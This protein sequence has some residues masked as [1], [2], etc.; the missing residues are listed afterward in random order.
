MSALPA[1]VE[2]HI[3]ELVKI[4]QMP[5]DTSKSSYLQSRAMIHS[6]I[7]RQYRRLKLPWAI[8]HYEQARECWEKIR[9]MVRYDVAMRSQML[10]RINKEVYYPLAFA[11][12]DESAR[13]HNDAVPGY[14]SADSPYQAHFEKTILPSLSGENGIGSCFSIL[15]SARARTF[16]DLAGR[17]A[18]MESLSPVT[19]ADLWPILCGEKMVEA[20]A[21]AYWL[22][23]EETTHLFILLPKTRKIV[24]NLIPI[25]ADQIADTY[26]QMETDHRQ[27]VNPV[28]PRTT[29]MDHWEMLQELK[30]LINPIIDE[31]EP[32]KSVVIIPHREMA[33]LPLGLIQVDSKGTFLIDR[34]P[35]CWVSSATQLCI[36]REQNIEKKR[37]KKVSAVDEILSVGVGGSNWEKQRADF[38]P[39]S[40]WDISQA[41]PEKIRSIP[42][43]WEKATKANFLEAAKQHRFCLLTCHGHFQ[44]LDVDGSGL[45]FSNRQL[46]TLSELQNER[47]SLKL[48]F[49]NTCVSAKNRTKGGEEPAGVPM[50]LCITGV[51]LVIGSLWDVYYNSGATTARTFFV[52]RRKNRHHQSTAAVL[53]QA[54]QL[55]REEFPDPY[56]WGGWVLFGDWI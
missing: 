52:S 20:A 10:V 2:S 14:A 26:R 3:S 34:N 18:D 6:D 23:T 48:I 37:A 8:P 46:L 30:P 50:S 32:N 55:T 40:E 19:L 17:S 35:I 44:Y 7:A 11:Y 15:E 31:V 5:G 28:K 41:E 53:Q 24:H 21:L 25:S 9:K 51:P 33:G 39:L 16:I 47:L 45:L 49:C 42:L 4:L 27:S 12:L 38:N 43:L 56:H 1:D 22:V 54:M 29:A 13:S 36:C